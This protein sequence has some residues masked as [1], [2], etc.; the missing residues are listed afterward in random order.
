MTNDRSEGTTG[1]APLE[2]AR[3]LGSSRPLCEAYDV[4]LLDLDGVCFAG[5][6]RILHAAASVNAARDS[7]MTLSFVTNNASRPPQAVVDKLEA[8]GI[9]ARPSE[10][11][12]AAMD[13]AALLREHIPQGSTVLVVGGEGVRQALVEAGYVT[14]YT[15]QDR[16]VAVLQGWDASVGWA[17]LSEAAYAVSQGALHVATNRDVTLPTERGLALGNGSL[18]AAV[19]SATGRQPL[20]GGKPHAGIYRRALAHSGGTAPLAVGDRLDTDLTGA[21][22][23][24]VPGLH[25]LTGVSDARDVILAP[26]SARPSFL[27]TDL[28]GLVQP[29]PGAVRLVEQESVWWQVGAWRACVRASQLVLDTVGTLGG[30]SVRVSLDAYRAL[31]CA[32]W[33]WTDSQAP[34]AAAGLTVP[35]IDVEASMSQAA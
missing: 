25:V 27:H 30:D 13:G 11:F 28:R 1:A 5:E 17:M 18:V 29:H 26:P 20:V 8:N 21:R 33:E 3:L 12:T 10:V 9:K 19:V 34:G 24:A 35:H 14:T 6:S 31:A 22:H 2:P 15:A 4:A 16:P 32:A 7:G 23:A